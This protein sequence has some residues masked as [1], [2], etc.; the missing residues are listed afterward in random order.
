MIVARSWMA[1]GALALAVS[2]TD[3][4]LAAAQSAQDQGGF[5]LAVDFGAGIRRDAAFDDYAVGGTGLNLAVGGFATPRLAILAQVSNLGFGVDGRSTL[6]QASG[7]V[8]PVVQYW[9]RDRVH[10]RAG[11]G[12]GFSKSKG[13]DEGPRPTDYVSEIGVGLVLGGGVTVFRRG[14]HDVQVGVQVTPVFIA[15]RNAHTAGLVFGYQWR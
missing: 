9:L 14:R 15:P 12:I 11:A 3:V 8:G 1:A 7:I 10:V 6:T 13:F 5:T 2:A 4:S